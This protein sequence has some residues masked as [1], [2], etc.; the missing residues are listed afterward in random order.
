MVGVAFGTIH[1]PSVIK[2]NVFPFVMLNYFMLLYISLFHVFDQNF[3]FIY[4]EG[5]TILSTY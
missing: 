2:L 5:V 4:A 1:N 3:W